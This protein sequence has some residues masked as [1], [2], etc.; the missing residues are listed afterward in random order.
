MPWRTKRPSESEAAGTSIETARCLLYA[1]RAH[2][3]LA[4]AT[5][6]TDLLDKAAATF[7]QAGLTTELGVAALERARLS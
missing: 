6:A 2:A 7:A 1:A 4:H 5:E 3:S